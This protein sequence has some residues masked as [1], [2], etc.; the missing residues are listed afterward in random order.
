MMPGDDR[1]PLGVGDDQHVVGQNAILAVERGDRLARIRPPDDDASPAYGLQVE[2]VQR[3]AQ[4]PEHVVGHVHDV[5]DRPHA[6]LDD[7][8][9]EPQR[10]FGD[11]HAADDSGR[12]ARAQIGV[13]DLD[14][15]VVVDGPVARRI[16]VAQILV[17]RRLR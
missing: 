13:E 2:G 1:G 8:R 9:L 5:V 15:D 11:V 4:G 7:A 17:E 10:R 6:R 14:G 12:V 3:L 16:G